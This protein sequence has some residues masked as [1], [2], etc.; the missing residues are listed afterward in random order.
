MATRPLKV[1]HNQRERTLG[2]KLLF[3]L[4]RFTLYGFVGIS[5]EVFFYTLVKVGRLIPVVRWLFAFDWR[6]DPRLGLSTIWDAPIR[7]LFGQCSLWMF[8]VYALASML[9]V[10]P[11]YRLL[12]RRPWPLRAVLYGL[13]ILAFEALSGW[14]LFWL[15][16][17][18]IWFY[19]DRLNVLGMT[20][21]AIGPVWMATGLL[22]ERIYRELMD[23]KVV[24]RLEALEAGAAQPPTQPTR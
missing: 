24:E 7:A 23:P 10:E 6:V 4:L 20:S 3:A 13:G 12:A 16:G 17:Y 8:P 5:A 19:D 14:G 21:L 15:T 18:K 22:V 2:L 11:V 1:K 9:C